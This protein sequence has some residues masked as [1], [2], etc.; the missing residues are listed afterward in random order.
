[1]VVGGWWLISTAPVYLYSPGGV[2]QIVDDRGPDP[3]R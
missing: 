3:G 1:M 2:M